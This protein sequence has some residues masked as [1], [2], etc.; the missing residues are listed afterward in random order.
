MIKKITFFV[1]A[2]MLITNFTASANTDSK[3]IIDMEYIVINQT[4]NGAT[5]ITDMVSFKNQTKEEYKGE[6][7]TDGVISVLLPPEAKGLTIQDKNIEIKQTETGFVTTKPIPANESIT[8]PYNYTVE[9]GKDIV[10][11]FNYPM[12]AYQILIPE[13]SGSIEVKDAKAVNQGLMQFQDKNF[14]VY[15][16]QNISPNQT[17]TMS[18]NKDKQPSGNEGQTETNKAKKENENLG[19]ITKTA[20]DFHNP[21]HLRMWAQSPLRKFDPHI[22]M[23]VLGAILIAGI[24]YFSY[25]R[26]KNSAKSKT[27]GLDKE[28]LLFQQL[29]AKQKA[30]LDKIIELEENFESGKMTEDEYKAKL[31]AYKQHLVQ[32]S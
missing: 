12:E 20:P 17:I 15:V 22:L 26:W 30:I 16:I 7:N 11:T 6:G 29:M 27:N 3:I 24:G 31:E 14:W 10:L 9:T 1:L 5:Q 18:Y 8:V 4:E 25:F 23:I 2:L 28:E 21:G 19:N 32:V 13:G